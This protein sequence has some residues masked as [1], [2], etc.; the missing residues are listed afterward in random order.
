MSL[1]GQGKGESKTI[2]DRGKTETFK[3][4]GYMECIH[5]SVI[6]RKKTDRIK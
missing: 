2:E 1:K 4:M 5:L 6:N 3:L